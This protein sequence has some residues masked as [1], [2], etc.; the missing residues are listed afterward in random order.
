MPEGPELH[1]ASRFVNK[2]C[3]GLV[4]SG[5][6]E[7]SAVSKNREVPFQCEAYIIS[8][9]SRG[10]E[11]KLTLTPIKEEGRK[12]GAEPSA[13]EP[14]REPPDPVDIVFRFGMSGSFELTVEEEL[15]KHAHLKF[16]SRDRPRQVLSFV[17]PRRFGSWEVNG[18]WQSDRGPC[19]MF[20][21][22]KFR[23]NVLSNLSDKAFDRPICEVLLNQKYFNGIGNYL[24]AE[25]LFRL[26]VPPFEKARAV[27]EALVHKERPAELSLSK[28]IKLKLDNPDILELCHLLPMEVINL[29]GE[30]YKSGRPDLPSAFT[31]WLRCYDVAG[32]QMLR[33]GNGRTIWF[34]GLPGPM[35]PKGSKGLK[36]KSRSKKQAD[37]EENRSL[38][39]EGQ[40]AIRRRRKSGQQRSPNVSKNRSEKMSAGGRAARRQVEEKTEVGEETRRR[41]ERHRRKRAGKVLPLPGTPAEAPRTRPTRS[42]IKQRAPF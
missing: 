11:V 29:G 31:A 7:K 10:K 2:V 19:V 15:P 26:K 20:E 17:D 6:V 22:E 35:A 28:K 25:V 39:P 33:D 3:S 37:E 27:L 36:A 5:S 24:R 8:A 41:S 1:L 18:T 40:A 42:T 16:F 30:G 9:V 12:E 14:G 38:K 21:Y 13:T 4:F 23:W 32:M 34:Q